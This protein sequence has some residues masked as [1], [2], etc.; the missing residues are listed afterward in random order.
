M[1][2]TGSAIT[3]TESQGHRLQPPAAQADNPTT[4]KERP[5]RRT[6]GEH[7]FPQFPTGSDG[8]HR[9]MRKRCGIGR[10]QSG[11]AK[12]IRPCTRKGA[13]AFSFHRHPAYA[14]TPHTP[15]HHITATPA[16][17]ATLAHACARKQT[18]HRKERKTP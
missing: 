2:G 8:P 16:Y 15:P 9:Y 13:G 14:A 11:T 12:H 17:A 18:A 1:H 7:R 4:R 10:K 3:V 5:E 6:A